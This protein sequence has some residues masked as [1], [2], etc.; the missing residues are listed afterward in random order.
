[1]AV[2]AAGPSSANRLRLG[3]NPELQQI[4]RYQNNKSNHIEKIEPNY[5]IGY[6]ISPL[7]LLL[8]TVVLGFL[9]QLVPLRAPDSPPLQGF[10]IRT[11]VRQLSKISWIRMRINEGSMRTWGLM[12]RT[13]NFWKWGITPINKQI[14]LQRQTTF[15]L[16]AQKKGGIHSKI[17]KIT[18]F[19]GLLRRYSLGISG[20]ASS[21]SNMLYRSAI[22]S[23]G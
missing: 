19:D 20:T 17:Q 2:P 5:S 1:M 18:S 21:P 13:K 10:L 9:G 16:Q 7:A 23:S 8:H 3:K 22:A 15:N 14:V 11:F 12:K 6:L 4:Q